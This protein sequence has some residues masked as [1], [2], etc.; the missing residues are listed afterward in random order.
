MKLTL[1]L[2]GL[3]AVSAQSSN[4]KW[5]SPTKGQFVELTAPNLYGYTTQ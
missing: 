4:P 2:V 3:A 1:L 5:L